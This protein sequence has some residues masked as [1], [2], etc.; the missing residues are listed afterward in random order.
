MQPHGS[1]LQVGK[2]IE[3]CEQDA[4]AMLGS[5]AAKMCHLRLNVASSRLA[6]VSGNEI[7]L[8]E[9]KKFPQVYQMPHTLA[10]KCAICARSDAVVLTQF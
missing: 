3:P 5:G 7:L 1:C 2:D 6:Q 4:N 10:A 9:P 8:V